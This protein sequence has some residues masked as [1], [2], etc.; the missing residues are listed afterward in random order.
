MKHLESYSNHTN[1]FNNLYNSTL[2]NVLT[3][4]F[5][6]DRFCKLVDQYVDFDWS[7][8]DYQV[9]LMTMNA[10]SGG[11]GKYED[12]PEFRQT[13]KQKI[14]E[15]FANGRIDAL[16]L[17]NYIVSS[18]RHDKPHILKYFKKWKAFDKFWALHNQFDI[19][20]SNIEQK[21][22]RKLKDMGL[23]ISADEAVDAIHQWMIDYISV[24][25]YPQAL[26]IIK[27]L[28]KAG[29]LD[30]TYDDNNII[31]QLI[32]SVHYH[33][34]KQISYYIYQQSLYLNYNYI[35]INKL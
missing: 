19:F 5:D 32:G 27:I 16:D 17:F 29:K 8:K 18:D 24:G 30:L 15:L 35:L 1:Y 26:E 4:G 9:L 31:L 22:N 23:D 11:V 20:E 25:V 21:L 33:L 3:S 28:D 6:A 14:E 7:F 2:F 34:L 10:V 12:Y 13:I